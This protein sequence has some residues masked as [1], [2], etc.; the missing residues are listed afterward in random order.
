MAFTSDLVNAGADFRHIVEIQANGEVKRLRLIDLP[1]DDY[2]QHKG[3]LWK[4]DFA[5]FHFSASCIKISDIQAV[6]IQ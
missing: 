2:L 6:F 4:I 5:D 3:D 1:A